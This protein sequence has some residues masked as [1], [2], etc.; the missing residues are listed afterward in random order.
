MAIRCQRFL[1]RDH[2]G[3]AVPVDRVQSKFDITPESDA[4]CLQ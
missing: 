1:D 3:R 2:E 4:S